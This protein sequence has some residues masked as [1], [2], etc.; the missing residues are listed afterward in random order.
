MSVCVH[1]QTQQETEL[2]LCVKCQRRIVSHLEAI[3]VLHQVLVD[4]A[5]MKLPSQN[6]EEKTTRQ[7]STGAPADLYILSLTDRR[8]DARAVLGSHLCRWGFTVPPDTASICR[9]I[10]DLLPWAS[11]K[12]TNIDE[13]VWDVNRQ[14]GKLDRAVHGGRRPPAPVGCPVFVPGAGQCSGRLY[15]HSDGTVTCDQC[16]SVWHFDDWRRLGALL[17]VDAGDTVQ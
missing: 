17:A 4:N 14:Y 2:Y 6:L 15:L 7:V 8:S 3:P 16:G 10:S 13:L 5:W 11:G 12:F 9:R 1:C